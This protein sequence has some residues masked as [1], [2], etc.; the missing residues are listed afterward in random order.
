MS[1]FICL[2]LLTLA[3]IQAV[4]GGTKIHKRINVLPKLSLSAATFLATAVSSSKCL[5]A[6]IAEPPLPPLSTRVQLIRATNNALASS[7]ALEAL[8]K[9][10]QYDADDKV[11]M[12]TNTV[13]LLTPIVEMEGEVACVCD[14]FNS[15]EDAKLA[16]IK[17]VVLQDKYTTPHIKKM[18]NRYSDNIYYTDPAKANLYLA[19]GALPDSMQTQRYLLRND[20]ITFMDNV[21]DDFKQLTEKDTKQLDEQLYADIKDDVDQVAVALKEYLQCTNADEL[22]A[23]RKMYQSSSQSNHPIS[24]L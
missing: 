15:K 23:A 7:K 14:L 22:A 18:F 9:A 17:S 5:A 16:T 8:R 21:R 3:Q 2:F 24:Y 4:L 20:I 11:T 1:R 10:E 13:L 12:G 19:G 6:G